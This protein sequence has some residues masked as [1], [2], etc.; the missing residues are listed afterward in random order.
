MAI[1]Y[2]SVGEPNIYPSSTG[3]ANSDSDSF[4]KSHTHNNYLVK[5]TVRAMMYSI[6]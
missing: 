5:V 1:Y 3:M 2:L 4:R 6:V